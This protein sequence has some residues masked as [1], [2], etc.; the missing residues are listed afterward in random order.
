MTT[1]LKNAVLYLPAIVFALGSHAVY[2][3]SPQ[4]HEK[5]AEIPA[6]FD[7]QGVGKGIMPPATSTY[8]RGLQ[9]QIE[10][11]VGRE[12]VLHGI[13]PTDAI[14]IIRH[15]SQDCT[16]LSGDDGISVGCWMFNLKANPRVSRQCAMSFECSTDLALSWMA[17]GKMNLWST[18][19]FRCKW[20]P[21]DAPPGCD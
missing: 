21:Y 2:P 5:P 4:T 10:A 14:F 13:N 1:K 7:V 6:A 12:A 20:Y 9:G 8:Q 11:Y 16:N 18:W 15:E 17:A 3:V 19:R